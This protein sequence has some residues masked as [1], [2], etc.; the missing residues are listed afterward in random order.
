MLLTLW[1]STFFFVP[2]Y[3]HTGFLSV[4]NTHNDFTSLGLCISF[5][6]CLTCLTPP[7]L[8]LSVDMLSPKRVF[9]W[10]PNLQSELK[11]VTIF[12]KALVTLWFFLYLFVN[13]LLPAKSKCLRGTNLS[14]LANSRCSI[15]SYSMHGKFCIVVFHCVEN[16]VKVVFDDH[17][18]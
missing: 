11:P 1:C 10:V 2:H 7:F 18:S 9:I 6:L 8:K 15:N 14:N 16:R 3:C 5:S 12:C 13:Y 17:N 4:L